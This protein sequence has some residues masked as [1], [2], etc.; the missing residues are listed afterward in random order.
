MKNPGFKASKFSMI[1]PQPSQGER[2]RGLVRVQIYFKAPLSD[3][4]M[5]LDMQYLSQVHKSD[6]NVKITATFA[7]SALEMLN[8]LDC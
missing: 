7:I 6:K 8:L 2:S 5:N 3:I 1:E 4:R